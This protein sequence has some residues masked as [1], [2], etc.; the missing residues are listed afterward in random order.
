MLKPGDD[1]PDFELPD[2]Q[3]GTFRLHTMLKD[4]PV[5]LYFYPADF[6]PVCTKQACMFRDAHQ[7]LA[8]RGVRVVGI[9]SMALHTHANFRKRHAIP[10]PL[11]SDPERKVIGPYGAD[12]FLG[13]VRRISYLIGSDGRIVDAARGDLGLS[14][15]K[16]FTER[17]LQRAA[18]NS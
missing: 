13:L 15:H 4:G 18:Q 16:A 9:N 6:T 11:L 8:A 12:G 14:E 1:A 7:E 2:G 3:G 10:F 5:V 17:T